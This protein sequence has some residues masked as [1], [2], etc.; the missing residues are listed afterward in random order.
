M[1]TLSYVN[2][3]GVPAGTTIAALQLMLEEAAAAG[4]QYDGILLT[5]VDPKLISRYDTSL[6]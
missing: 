1:N 4:K 6:G 2:Y 5:G 3:I